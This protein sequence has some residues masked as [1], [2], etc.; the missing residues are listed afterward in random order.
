V[1]DLVSIALDTLYRTSPTAI[2]SWSTDSWPVQ[3]INAAHGETHRVYVPNL[4]QITRSF[5]HYATIEHFAIFNLHATSRAE[6]SWQDTSAHLNTQILRPRRLMVIPDLNPSTNLVLH[7][8]DA[9]TP[10]LYLIAGT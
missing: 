4:T 6:I 5:S 8:I 2:P 3:T 10:M 1:A 7:G 9:V